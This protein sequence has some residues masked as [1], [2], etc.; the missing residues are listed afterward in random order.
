MIVTIHDARKLGYCLSGMSQFFARH[1]LDF[2]SFVQNGI[3]EQALLN[4]GDFM[5]VAVV[6]MAQKRNG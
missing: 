5:A 6:E 2:R 4:T 1:S 3:D